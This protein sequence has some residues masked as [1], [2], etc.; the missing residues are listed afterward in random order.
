MTLLRY[1]DAV[2]TL[3]GSIYLAGAM[4]LLQSD[5][6]SD[7]DEGSIGI[8]RKG[9]MT[10]EDKKRRRQEINRQSAR[11]IRERRSQEMERLKQQVQACSSLFASSPCKIV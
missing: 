5:N 8:K 6:Q 2:R 4:L 11:R 7:E 10:E 9:P 3:L 1:V